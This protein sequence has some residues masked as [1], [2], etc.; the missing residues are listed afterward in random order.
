MSIYATAAEIAIRQFGDEEYVQLIIQS[1]PPHI[2][3]TGP[4]WDFLPPPVD[5]YGETPRAVV[6]VRSDT[7]KGTPRSHQEYVDPLLV[8]SGEE[9]QEVRF[10]DLLNRLEAAL[11]ARRA[12]PRPWAI[13]LGPD[14]EKKLFPK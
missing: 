3:A 1:V 12:E 13:F 6:I 9:W 4:E 7:P 5:P 8:L 10:V 14:G 2:D 11:Y